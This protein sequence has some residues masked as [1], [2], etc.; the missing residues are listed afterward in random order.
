[1]TTA[2]VRAAAA[3]RAIGDAAHGAGPVSLDELNERASLLARFDHS[4]LVPA[5]TFLRVVGRLTH[6]H[7]PGGP[8]RA[9]AI[10]GRR[11]FRYHSVYYDT[12]ELRSFHDHRQG[13]R[14]RFKIRERVYEDTGER[15]FEIKLKGPRGDTVKRR[16]PLT[17]ADTP[18][19]P[20][21]RGF[22]TDTLR[23]AYGIGAP[24]ALEPSLSTDYMRATFV[25]DGERITCD[26]ALVCHDLRIGRTVRCTDDLVLVETKTT[27]HLTEADRL[28]HAH[29]I[30]PA[31]FTKYCSA[32]AALRPA[33]PANRWRRTARRAFGAAAPEPTC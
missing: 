24:A 19:G 1:M 11:A 12:P 2:P 27:G 33:L 6:P 21:C 3:V 30:R 10:D 5:D 23:T 22:L 31:V 4:Y 26:A 32:F 8:Y 16:C 9:L 15:Q 29:G 20:D 18:L 13:R 17:G 25:A 14:R 7:R 28:L